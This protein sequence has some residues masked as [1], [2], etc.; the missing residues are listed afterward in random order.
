MR[1]DSSDAG[2]DCKKL[3]HV[4]AMLYKI[5]SGIRY[6][7]YDKHTLYWL[8][9]APIGGLTHRE[10]ILSAYIADYRSSNGKRLNV[11]EY[12][13]LLKDS[14]VT[15]I[16]QLGSL[17]QIA[18][19]LDS[20]ETGVIE[21]VE[22]SFDHGALLLRLKCRSQAYLEIRQLEA[23]AKNFKKVWDVKLE[24]EMTPSSIH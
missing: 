12:R 13:S 20:S 16:Q 18:V 5:G 6:H 24:W 17:L 21:R 4:A 19:A 8:T 1:L 23:T 9:H 7:Q 22:A 11:G 2:E 14:D 15:L 10:S 3:I